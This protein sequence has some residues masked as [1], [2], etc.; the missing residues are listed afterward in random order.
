MPGL[1]PNIEAYDHGMLCRRW[2]PGLL[3]NVRKFIRQARGGA[4][5]RAGESS[6]SRDFDAVWPCGWWVHWNN[7]K[8]IFGLGPATRICVALRATD[9]HEA[10]K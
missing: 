8:F 10:L 7:S 2:E 1:Y 4:R 3:G 6:L 9:M 5:R